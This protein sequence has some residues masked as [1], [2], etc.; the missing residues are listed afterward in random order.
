MRSLG[1]KWETLIPC[2][3]VAIF[4]QLPAGACG[5]RLYGLP[6]SRC[7]LRLT[8]RLLR[9]FPAKSPHARSLDDSG[10][11]HCVRAIDSGSLEAG[12]DDREARRFGRLFEVAC[13]RDVRC[14]WE[15][16]LLLARQVAGRPLHDGDRAEII[17]AEA[18]SALPLMDPI[19]ERQARCPEPQ[20]HP[21]PGPQ[22]CP[23]CIGHLRRHR[24]MGGA[25][26]VGNKCSYHHPHRTA[27]KDRSRR[28]MVGS[29]HPYDVAPVQSIACLRIQTD[30]RHREDPPLLIKVRGEHGDLFLSG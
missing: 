4:G 21:P 2:R 6:S 5:N 30:V 15:H 10:G 12:P 1:G 19:P 20:E 26:L 17:I 18:L 7:D 27:R 25:A 13:T 22:W 16:A 8:S 11:A 23:G 14:K 24:E 28:V 9:K 3:W 29:G